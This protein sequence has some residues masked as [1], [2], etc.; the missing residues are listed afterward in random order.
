VR[1]AFACSRHEPLLASLRGAARDREADIE[2]L[3]HAHFHDF[4]S[5]VD[6]LRSLLASA[7]GRREQTT[8]LGLK[9][10]FAVGEGNIL[11]P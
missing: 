7:G 5:A 11:G 2:E 10:G 8:I 4:I 6:D 3:C 1:W 9:C